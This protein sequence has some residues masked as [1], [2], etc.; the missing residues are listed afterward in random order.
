MFYIAQNVR[1]H[2][3]GQVLFQLIVPAAALRQKENSDVQT[4]DCAFGLKVAPATQIIA[5]T[6]G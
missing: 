5:V 1:N 2:H 4:A 3:L 6:V